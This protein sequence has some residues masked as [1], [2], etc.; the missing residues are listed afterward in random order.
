MKILVVCQYYK[1]EPFR[2]SDIC[3]A[4]VAKGHEVTVLTGVPN[5]PMGEI[6]EGYQGQDKRQEWVNGVR[7]FRHWTLPRKQGAVHRLLNYLSFPLS[8]SFAVW[9]NHYR[10]LDGS[11]FDV[12]LVNQLSPVLMATAGVVYKKKYQK[13]L[14]LYCL[15]LWPLSLTAGGVSEKSFLYRL[16]GQMAK[17][18]YQASDQILVTSRNFTDYLVSEHGVEADKIAYLPQYAED[19]FQPRFELKDKTGLDLMFAGNIGVSQDLDTVIEAARL[20]EHSHKN[21]EVHFHIVGD[22]SEL[23]RLKNL[24]AT[25]D[26]KTV[27]FYGRKPVEEM[28]AFYELADAMLVTLAGA[29][30][31]A[32]TL[33]GKVQ[34]YMAAGKPIIGAIN[35]ET[36]KVVEEAQ[37]GFVAPAQDVQT[38]VKDILSFSILTAEERLNLSENARSYYE[39]EFSKEKYIKQLEKYLKRGYHENSND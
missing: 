6:Y 30:A 18:I 16:F 11:D 20:L 26:L 3:E 34:S 32:E 13:P 21:V 5:Y 35:G 14:L 15:D 39:K 38:L 24:V 36:Q 7:V 31:L 1:P 19:V 22:G 27:T 17:K 9:R 4:L 8:S 12:V 25:Q 23:E 29:S 2:I 10:A 33:P 37:C 28:P